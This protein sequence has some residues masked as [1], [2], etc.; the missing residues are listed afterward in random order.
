MAAININKE[1]FEQMVGNG[2][3]ILVDFWAP[4]CVTAVESPP[5]MTELRKAMAIR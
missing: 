4:W 5:R 1:Q 2:K 3:T